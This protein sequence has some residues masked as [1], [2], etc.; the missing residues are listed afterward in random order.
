M[1][2]VAIVTTGFGIT[3]A[4]PRVAGSV[5][6]VAPVIGAI[7]LAFGGWYAMAAWGLIVYP[8]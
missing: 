5:N 4:S 3:L 2:C 1:Q 8:L 6:G 7:S